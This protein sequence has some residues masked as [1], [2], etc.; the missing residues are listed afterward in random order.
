MPVVTTR[1]DVSMTAKPN[2]SYRAPHRTLQANTRSIKDTIVAP[3]APGAPSTTEVDPQPKPEIQA[4]T[5]TG[6]KEIKQ[7]DPSE[8]KPTEPKAVTLSPQLTAL[9]RKEQAFRKQ[10]QAFK[11]QQEAFKAQQ[12]EF[13]TQKSEYAQYAKLK[14]RLSSEDYAVL[15][16]LGVSY[17]KWT[18][19]LLNKPETP[20][21][22][23]KI[24]ALETEVKTLRQKQDEQERK[25]KEQ[26]DKQYE[27]TVK[28]YRNEIKDL[29]TKDPEFDSVKSLKAED[30]VLQHILDTFNEDGEVL[31]VEEA[32]KEVEEILVEDA[33]AMSK[34][35]KVQEKTRPVEPTKEKTLPPPQKQTI[36][37]LTNTVAPTTTKTF[38]QFQHMSPQ[39]RIAQAIAKAQRQG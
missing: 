35:K 23:P 1:N 26:V 14:D 33:L 37:T 9:A 10:E 2:D 24:D 34:L 16:E 19:H 21:A 12:A 7:L 25:A 38:P 22:N 32:C 3:G 15:D 17:E 13:E 5:A 11:A 8:E 39:Q 31:S 4:N 30:H 28:Q 29:V 20:A 18:N 6:D 27:A 36:K